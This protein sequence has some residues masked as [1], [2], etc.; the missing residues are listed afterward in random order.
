MS[1]KEKLS[2][3]T[4]ID[5]K[6]LPS[7]YQIIGDI[8]LLKLSK[9]KILKQKK[10]IAAASQKLL[11]YIKTVC[12]IKQVS[13]EFR[14]PKLKILLG[15]TT[16]TIHKENGIFYKIDVS[17]IM[18]SKGNLL[19]R[20]RLLEKIKPGE[21]IV[22]MFAGIGYFSLNL[23]KYT[24]TEKIY[25]I[26]K[27]KTAFDYLVENVRLN[28]IK[29]IEPIYGD[30]RKTKIP[31]KADRVLMGYFPGTDKFLPSAF[32]FLKDRGIIVYHNIFSKKELWDKPLKNLEKS[33]K[34]N[35]FRLDKVLEKKIV[36]DYA[37]NVYHVVVEAEFRK[38]VK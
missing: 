31:H 33:A 25:S 35:G 36:K 16:E 37:P 38:L 23:A 6:L 22:D 8:L 1:F 3:L 5:S 2:E 27:N 20:K 18:F 12:E 29:N 30:C 11:P 21:I 4:K 19:E 28:K 10:Q 7:S 9:I 24:N 17:K 34:E 26:E 13:G 15:K 32:G 14:K